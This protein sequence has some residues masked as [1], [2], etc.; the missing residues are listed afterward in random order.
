MIRRPP[1]S[2][3]TATLFPYAT[4]FRSYLRAK[5]VLELG[6]GAGLSALLCAFLGADV[7]LTDEFTDLAEENARICHSNHGVACQVVPLRWGVDSP[8]PTEIVAGSSDMILGAELTPLRGAHAALVETIA[9]SAPS[10]RRSTRA[11][12]R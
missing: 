10:H 2:T 8:S 6:C 12:C 1:R 5:R 3:R 7:V 4:L 9:S 11:S